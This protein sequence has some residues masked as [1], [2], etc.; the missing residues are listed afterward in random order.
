MAIRTNLINKDGPKIFFAK[1]SKIRT[2]ISCISTSTRT[3]DFFKS[4]KNLR[5]VC[6]H[7]T[8]MS[9]EE[10][11]DYYAELRGIVNQCPYVNEDERKDYLERLNYLLDNLMINDDRPTHI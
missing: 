9:G 2:S 4:T 7:S 8:S 6:P 5:N 3:V 11:I 1:A 10:F